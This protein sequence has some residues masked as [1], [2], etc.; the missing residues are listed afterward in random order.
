VRDTVAVDVPAAPPLDE[1]DGIGGLFAQ[2]EREQPAPASAPRT[3]VLPIP[4]APAQAPVPAWQPTAPV[5]G[6]PAPPPRAGGGG[7]TAWI[8]AGVLLLVVVLGVGGL[9]LLRD[10]EGGGNGGASGDAAPTA[11]TSA[12]P[13]PGDVEQVDGVDYRLEAATVD[14]SCIGHAY[15]EVSN[16]FAGTDCTG[17]SRALYSTALEGRPVVVSISRVRMPDT[18]T[19]R[20]LQQLTD[21]NGSG[22]VSDLLREGVRYQGSPAALSGAEYASAISGSSVTIVESSWADPANTGNAAEID[23]V[24]GAAL[25]LPTPDFPN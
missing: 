8:V 7:R 16:F 19:A 24:A 21:R 20:S 9:W 4:A 12:G 13:Q 11:E 14:A 10:G 18:A 5:T 15:G 3:A 25:V 22:N 1:T 2:A 6:P 17:L 23:V